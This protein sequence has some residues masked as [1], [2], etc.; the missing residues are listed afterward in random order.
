VTEKSALERL[1]AAYSTWNETKGEGEHAKNAW[2]DLLDDH[3]RIVS[4][5]EAASGMA[6]A[7]NRR[8][9]AEAA[10]YLMAILNEWKM[11]HFTP[12]TFVHDGDKIAM[13]GRCAWTNRRT[14]KTME[15]DI[16]H[17]WKFSNGKA[18]HLTEVFD[19]ARAAAAAMP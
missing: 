13:F 2:L 18:V 5:D 19:S 4:M 14:Q 3:A 12:E 6:F 15:C 1:R 16:A 11:V 9:K 7:Q 17:L 10:D 8:S